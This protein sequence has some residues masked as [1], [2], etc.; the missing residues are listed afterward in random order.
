MTPYLFDSMEQ[1]VCDALAKV[2][3]ILLRK[4]QAEALADIFSKSTGVYP[5]VKSIRL[6]W[7]VLRISIDEFPRI[8]VTQLTWHH[9]TEL[10]G[11]ILEI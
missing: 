10:F 8:E 5:S 6:L 9:S 7:C 2:H 11:F 4:S 3:Y 1:A